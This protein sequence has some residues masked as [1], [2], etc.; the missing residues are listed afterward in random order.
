MNISKLVN[1]NYTYY[2]INKYVPY[3][4]NDS[5]LI[6]HNENRLK[7]YPKSKITYEAYSC[8]GA[9][10]YTLNYLLN[11]FNINNK[12]M[13][14]KI[15]YGKYKED[16]C[17]LLTDNDYIIDPTYRQLFTNNNNIKNYYNTFLYEKCPFIFVGKYSDLLLFHKKLSFIH[18]QSYKYLLSDKNLIFYHNYNISDIKL[19][20]K[21]V[22]TSYDYSLEKGKYFLNL[23]NNFDHSDF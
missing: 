22:V 11:K 13:I 23:H 4:F 16:H 17:F 1:S 19:D 6:L 12:L 14:K 15:G 2:F 9:V 10:C 3:L 18:L 20:F 5:D 21:N 7:Y 8:C